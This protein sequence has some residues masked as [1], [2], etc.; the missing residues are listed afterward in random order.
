MT[1]RRSTSTDEAVIE[2][3]KTFE[4]PE[5][6][7][8]KDTHYERAIE[9]T[10]KAFQPKETLFPIS[11]PDL[12]YYQWKLSVSAEAPWTIPSFTFT[13]SF[14]NLDNESESPKLLERLSKLSNWISDTRV[15]IQ[16]Y[17]NAKYAAGIT[18]NAFPRFHNLYNEIFQYNRVLVHQIKE[19]LAP[20]WIK[21]KPQP[22]YWLTL[23][24]RS[25]V[26]SQDEPDK[27]RAVFGAPKLLLM[28]EN[29]FIWPLQAAYL[30]NPDTGRLLWGREMIRGGWKKLFSEIHAQGKPSTYLSL[31]WSQF[32]K[33]LLHEVIHDVHTIWR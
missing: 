12:R 16:Q 18:I 1:N 23:H 33:R 2:D 24:A 3:F 11:F 28:V 30:N 27:I 7:V 14:R 19:G 15:T 22:Y 5:F 21:G 29:M 8:P 9:F 17:L 31:D 13:P 20:F 32:D 25:H 6:K 26:V 4:F 10:R